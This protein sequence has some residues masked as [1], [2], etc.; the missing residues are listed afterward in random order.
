MRWRALRCGSRLDD[1]PGIADADLARIRERGVRL[2]S[3]GSGSGL[4]LAIAGEM[5]E[6][7][8]G[9]LVLENAQAGFRASILLPAA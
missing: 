4:G 1:S 2:D 9:R 8:D 6:Q 7:A 5:V 3:H